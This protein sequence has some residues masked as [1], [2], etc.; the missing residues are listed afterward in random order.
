MD[1]AEGFVDA[2]VAA[3]FIGLS[4]RRT[5]QLARAGQLPGHPV[6]HGVRRTWRFLLSELRA[7]ILAEDSLPGSKAVIIRTGSPR[8]PNRRN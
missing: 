1:V 4:R 6:G 2:N 3:R 8:Q 7:T 5:L